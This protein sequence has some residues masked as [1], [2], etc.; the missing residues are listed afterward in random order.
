MSVPVSN[1]RRLALLLP[2]IFPGLAVA[3]LWFGDLPVDDGARASISTWLRW[4]AILMPDGFFL[5]GVLNPEGDPAGSR[6]W[7]AAAGHGPDRVV[8]PGGLSQ[9]RPTV[10]PVTCR[11]RI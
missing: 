2:L 11:D 9:G 8:R 4:G 10:I 1:R 6:R 3:A 7:A 5:G